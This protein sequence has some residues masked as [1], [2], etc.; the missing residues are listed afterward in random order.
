[1]PSKM[2]RRSIALL[3]PVLMAL[4]VLL[5]PSVSAEPVNILEVGSYEASIGASESATFK[6]VLYNN[7]NSSYL[8]RVVPTIASDG[9]E[10]TATA[11]ESFA[12]LEPG[13]HWTSSVTVASTQEVPTQR[14]DLTVVF[15]IVKMD[16]PSQITAVERTAAVDITALFEKGGAMIFAW[17]NNLPAPLNS[18]WGT[19]AIV[20]LVW[21]GIAMLVRFLVFPI[22]QLLCKRT[23]NNLDNRLLRLLRMPTL[24]VII[25]FGLVDSLDILNIPAD[26][27]VAIWQLYRIITIMVVAW[28]IYRIFNDI[29]IGFAEKWSKKT[30]S[31]VDDVLIPLLQKAGM[32]I[33]PVFAAGAA[34]SVVGVDLTLAVASLGVMGLVIGLAAQH[35]LG[36]L[37]SGI[38]LMLDRPFKIGDVVK[39]DTGEICRVVK[40]GLRTTQLYNTTDHDLIVLPNDMLANRKVENWSRPDNRHSQG[41][42]VTVAYGTDL[43]KVHKLLLKVADENPDVIKEPG[44]MPYVRTANLGECSVEVKVWYWVDLKNMW[45][46]ASEMRMAVERRLR[47]EGVEIPFPQR[48]I[49]LNGPPSK[50]ERQKVID[51]SDTAPK[52]A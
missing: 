18:T 10:V 13:D 32:L 36:N 20:L 2:M 35:S 43:E 27:H 26:V 42:E 31:G 39:L 9:G 51:L 23:K 38:L 37:F 22:V 48:V 8:I 30:E 19:F 52:E 21:V 25:S 45:R 3:L 11:A 44:Q 28:T 34:L 24:I 12:T 40:I 46:V 41:T 29:V 17:E 7:D 16:D 47:E 5:A 50:E 6:W 33:I 14:A 49:T 4:T 15:E 1:M